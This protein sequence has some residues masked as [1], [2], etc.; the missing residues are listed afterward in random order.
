M[1]GLL[2]GAL[3]KVLVLVIILTVFN[4][5]PLCRYFGRAYK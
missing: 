4:N 2:L 5:D 1:A 3:G